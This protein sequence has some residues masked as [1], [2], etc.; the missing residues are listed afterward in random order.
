MLRHA[1][2]QGK[3]TL[4]ASMT[5]CALLALIAGSVQRPLYETRLAIALKGPSESGTASKPDDQSTSRVGEWFLQTQLRVIQSRPL[6]E[7]VLGQLTDDERARLLESPHFWWTHSTYDETVEE[8]RSHLVSWPGNQTSSDTTESVIQISLRSP[9]PVVGAHF[10]TA[11]TQELEDVNVERAWRASRHRR[12]WS[13]LLL[14]DLRRKWENSAMVLAN[15]AQSSGAANR[16]TPAFIAQLKLLEQ[17]ASSKRQTYESTAAAVGEADFAKISKLSKIRILVPANQIAQS[18]LPSHWEIGGMGAFGGLLIG[19]IFL[20]LL[21]RLPPV[22]R[23]P[24]D[25]SQESGVSFIGVIP[26]DRL[27]QSESGDGPPPG[28]AVPISL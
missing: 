21:D 19:L 26:E 3:W 15:F 16:R 25:L 28:V 9:D 13:E 23:G 1:L 5:I 17:A 18:N 2:W 7:R 12:Q 8:L 27:A 11:L 20:A 24:S 6:L 4:L 14:S 22:F 10:L